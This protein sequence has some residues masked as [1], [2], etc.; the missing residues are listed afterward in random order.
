MSSRLLTSGKALIRRSV[1]PAGALPSAQ[2]DY[3][4]VCVR[5]SPWQ[6]K[7]WKTLCFTTHVLGRVAGTTI[8]RSTALPMWLH[9]LFLPEPSW[10]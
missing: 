9:C 4:M 6:E 1:R 10:A 2:L 5:C 3:T 7:S 8:G